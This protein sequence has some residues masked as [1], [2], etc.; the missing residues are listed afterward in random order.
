MG[1][2]T[3]NGNANGPFVYTGFRPAFII[4][5]STANGHNWEVYDTQRPYG[6]YNPAFR[7]LYA[8]HNYVEETHATLPA[9]DILNDGFKPRS[10]W[11]EFNKSNDTILYMAFAEQPGTTPYDTQTNAR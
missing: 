2:Y 6:K 3:G 10:T 11:D 7:P 9:L 5:K 1:S 8:N 4:F